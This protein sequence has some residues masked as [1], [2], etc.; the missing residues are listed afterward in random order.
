[1]F[2][3]RLI[4]PLIR[5]GVKSKNS[6]LALLFARRIVLRPGTTGVVFSGRKIKAMGLWRSWE[7]ASMAWKRSRVRIP[8]GPPNLTSSASS[9]RKFSSRECFV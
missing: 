3:D 5:D 6:K 4:V 1:M 9:P 7:R 8:S 2:S